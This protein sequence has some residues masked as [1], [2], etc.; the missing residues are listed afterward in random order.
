MPRG[1]GGPPNI[2]QLVN[3]TNIELVSM[4]LKQFFVYTYLVTCLVLLAFALPG[5]WFQLDFSEGYLT[6][7]NTSDVSHK[8]QQLEDGKL[9]YKGNSPMLIMFKIGWGERTKLFYENVNSNNTYFETTKQNEPD[10]RNYIGSSSDNQVMAALYGWKAAED[11]INDLLKSRKPNEIIAE[12]SP[13]SFWPDLFLH[14]LIGAGLIL[15][16][17]LTSVFFWERCPKKE[18][19]KREK[20]SDR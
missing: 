3:L 14:W 12:Y 8:L 16:I 6:S 7:A 4:N 13:L 20:V 2:A 19:T 1:Q 18:K 5:R 9:G 17:G 11:R 10:M 15:L